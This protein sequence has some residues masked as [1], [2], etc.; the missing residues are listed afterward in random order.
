MAN[1]KRVNQNE[2]NPLK[3]KGDCRLVSLSYDILRTSQISI[4]VQEIWY[5]IKC[6][7]SDIMIFSVKITFWK[8]QEADSYH[9]IDEIV[10]VLYVFENS[11]DFHDEIENLITFSWYIKIS[12]FDILQYLKNFPFFS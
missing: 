7:G 5:F 3:G 8:Y 1:A 2:K 4:G 9:V 12:N 6:V 10:Y 11:G